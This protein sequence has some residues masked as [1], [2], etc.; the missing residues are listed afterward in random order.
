MERADGGVVWVEVA[1]SWI[2][3]ADGTEDRVGCAEEVGADVGGSLFSVGE[4]GDHSRCE[5]T[6][7]KH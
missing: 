5:G 6:V 4:A 7:L 2:G 1:D 3:E